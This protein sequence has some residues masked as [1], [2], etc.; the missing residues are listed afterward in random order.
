MRS[1]GGGG[2]YLR[3]GFLAAGLGA[4]ADEEAGWLA[5]EALVA[6]ERHGGVEEGLHLRRH[7]AEPGREAEE[8][9]VGVGEPVGVHDGDDVLAVAAAAAVVG[10]HPREHGGGS[11]SGRGRGSPARPGRTHRAPLPAPG[12]GRARTWSRTRRRCAPAAAPPPAPG[13]RS[14]RA[15]A[16]ATPALPPPRRRG[17]SCS[18]CSRRPCPS[19]VP[20]TTAS[21]GS[22]ARLVRRTRRDGGVWFGLRLARAHR[23]CSRNGGFRVILGRNHGGFRVILGRNHGGSRVVLSRNL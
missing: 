1:R 9:P 3:G 6:A 15:G 8:E 7:G 12:A 21:R 2:G 11:V 17:A 10:L 5:G 18:G 19:L 16:S 23:V 14:S 20:T 4:G 22:L 13:S